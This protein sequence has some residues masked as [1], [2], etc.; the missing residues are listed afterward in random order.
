MPV[1]YTI[2]SKGFVSVKSVNE[3]GII[4]RHV[5]SPGDPLDNEE[6]SVVAAAQ[7]SWTPEVVASYVTD[8][9]AITDKQAAAI[10]KA[11]ALKETMIAEIK[12]IKDIEGIKAYLKKQVL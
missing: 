3:D 4:H 5:L 6:A 2:D 1:T 9:K 12:A 7:Q 8:R 11:G 10:A